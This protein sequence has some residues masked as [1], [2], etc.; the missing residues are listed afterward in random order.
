MGRSGITDEPLDAATVLAAVAR[1]DHG[2]V[3]LFLGTVRDHFRGREVA[4]ITYDGYLPMGE[5][6]LARLVAD[7]ERDG[8]V[9]AALVHRLGRLAPGEASVV[10]AT[11]SAHRERAYESSRR[12]LERLKREAP[13]WKHEH[14]VDGSSTWREEEPLSTEP[15]R[16]L[17]TN[18]ST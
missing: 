12:L 14:Y 15:M 8:T 18:T 16:V 2:A 9:A 3:V 4:A 5:R 17:D 10:I 13:I 6:V 1:P 7:E 11:S